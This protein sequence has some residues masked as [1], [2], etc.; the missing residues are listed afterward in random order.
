MS[1]CIN[2]NFFFLIGWISL[3]GFYLGKQSFVLKNDFKNKNK[4]KNKNKT[5]LEGNSYKEVNYT[6]LNNIGG[7][8]V[9]TCTLICNKMGKQH[10]LYPH[11]NNVI[12]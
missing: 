3:I 12:M 5:S 8:E 10:Y 1:I 2:F 7:M 4:N 6:S 9:Y 11:M